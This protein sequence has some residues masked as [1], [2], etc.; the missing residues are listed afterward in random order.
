MRRLFQIGGVMV[1]ALVLILL[2]LG[3]HATSAQYSN[4][5]L[6]GTYV[7]NTSGIAQLL[8]PGQSSSAPGYSVSIGTLTNDGA[9]HFTGTQTISATPLGATP[10]SGA[11]AKPGA[12]MSVCQSQLSG[13]ST[14]NP[15]GTG[16]YTVKITPVTKAPGC[17]G[18]T[19]TGAIV[20][21]SADRC[22][23]TGTSFSPDDASA[24]SFLSSITFG[25]FRK[26]H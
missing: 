7:Y 25:E 26:Q 14:V 1:G 23:A 4:A 6:T 19:G 24:G 18:G 16:T 9:G 13:T 12:M 3:G 17:G 15:D 5:S 22:Q 2:G 8:V 20:I 11:N 10:A 21:E